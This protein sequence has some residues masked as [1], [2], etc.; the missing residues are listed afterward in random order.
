[1]SPAAREEL[2]VETVASEVA[3]A[4]SYLK[5]DR[6]PLLVDTRMHRNILLAT[7]SIRSSYSPRPVYPGIYCQKR[8]EYR[9]DVTVTLMT[10]RRSEAHLPP[11]HSDLHL[12]EVVSS[13]KQF[14]SLDYDGI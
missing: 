14:C 6:R 3:D 4:L 8:N 9:F 12:I 13:A 2:N 11:L 10:N 1:M 5:P 7:R